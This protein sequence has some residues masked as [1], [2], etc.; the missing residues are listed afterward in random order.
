MH[1]PLLAR[2]AATSL[3]LF[4]PWNESLWVTSDDSVRGGI[5]QSNLEIVAP[6][7][8]ENPFDEPIAKFYGTLDY[9]TLG[10][11][12]FASQ[13]TVD[14]WPGLD[15]SSYDSLI[16]EIPFSDGKTY[17]LN[18]K[19]TVLPLTADGREQS[20]TSW[21][22]DFQPAATALGNETEPT[23]TGNPERAVVLFSDLV[24]TYRGS[25]VNNSTPLNLT[26]IKRVNI[27]IRR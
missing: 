1:L 20:T 18:V 19:D 8:S 6:G 15:L 2:A 4:N 14:D 17:S 21:E 13:R 11:A 3:P 22:Y 9:A 16:L 24:P 12:G 7:T 10:G 25:V 5:S 23:G 26:G 27:M